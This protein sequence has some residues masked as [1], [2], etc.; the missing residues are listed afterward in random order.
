MASVFKRSNEK[1]QRNSVWIVNYR[2]SKGRR[3]Q[4]RGFTDKQASIQLG[5]KLEEDARKIRLGLMEDISPQHS[6]NLTDLIEDYLRHLEQRDVSRT[7]TDNLRV[8]LSKTIVACKFQ[9]PKEIEAQPIEDYLAKRRKQGL[10]KQ[11][12]NHY[13]QAMHQFCRWL[14]K[15]SILKT[16]PIADIP[17]LNADTDRRHD[18]R[19]LSIEEFQRLIAAAESGKRV[20]AIPGVDRAMMYVL[21]AWTGYRRGEIS[22]LTLDSFD[23]DASPPTVT[24]QAT[25]SKRRRK[26][27]QVLHPEVVER[28]KVWL[29]KRRPMH[30][31]WLFPLTKQTCGLDRRT[32][33]MMK[34]DLKNARIQWIKEATTEEEKKARMESDFLSY[35]NSAGQFADFHANRHTFITNLAKAGVSPK[36]TQLLAR[37]S[38]IRLT[39]NVY[40][41]S[42]I[43]EKAEAVGRLPGLAVVAKIDEP[44]Q[45]KPSVSEA[46]DSG[47]QHIRSTSAAEDGT[48]QHNLSAARKKTHRSKK[49]GEQH[50]SP[51]NRDLARHVSTC[52]P[53]S[54]ARPAGF[55]PATLG[56][57]GRV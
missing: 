14:I 41:H 29:S 10:G 25:Y 17:K 42:D 51:R 31:R 2:D 4:C 32:S 20:E 15:R 19:P 55:E 30:Q 45:Q 35:Q 39:M 28:L 18:R 33:K 50:N 22:S 6:A 38:D 36:V 9:I 53:K 13:R 7:Q 12:S 43:A 52:Q 8:R 16:N 34:A 23:L 47:S 5:I 3:R 44:Q 26:D 46:T 49:K 56:S 48:L 40:T 27:V 21:S 1:D 54:P 57:E 11:T 24:V 37:H